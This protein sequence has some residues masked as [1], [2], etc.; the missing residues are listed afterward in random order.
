[1]YAVPTGVR[2]HIKSSIPGT[3]A[4]MRVLGTRP[5]SSAIAKVFLPT[6]HLAS[7]KLFILSF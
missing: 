4:A 3:I 6:S 5:G 7:H 1:M 2:E